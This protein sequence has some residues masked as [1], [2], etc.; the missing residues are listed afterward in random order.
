MSDTPRLP[1][2]WRTPLAALALLL[3]AILGLYAHTASGMVAIWWRS[4]TYAH[5]FVV[6]VIS[7]W[8]IW[9]MRFDLAPLQPR[10][11]P[12]AWLLL[13]GAAGL[14]LAGDLVAVNAATQLALV[15]LLV[16][17]VPAV[18]GWRLAWAMAFPLGFLFFA[19]PIGDFMLPQLMEWTAS[20]TI[21]ALRLSGVPVYREGLQFIIPS[22]SWS[23]VEACSGIRY[24][25][26]SVTVGCLFAYLSYKSL[27]KR[28]IFVG[29]AILV[30]LVANWLRAYMIVMLGHL[31]GNEL[32]TGVDH[33]IYGWLFFG[34]VILAMLFVGAR[35]A[36]APEPSTAPL[37][38]G[39]TVL[40]NQRKLSPGIAALAALLI[41]ASPHLLERLLA[42]GSN[43]SPVVLS[44]PAANAPWQTAAQPPSNW[45]PAFQFPAATSHTGYVGPQGQAVG[46]HLTYYR[47]QNYERK[48]VSSE[49]LFVASKGDG[50][51][52][53]S[54][55]SAETRLADQPLTVSAAT[56]RQQ[57]GGLVAN[58][59]RLQA[60]RFYWVNG[61]FT[62]SD[63]QAK[64]Q[65][66]LSRLT[67]QGDDGAIVAIYAP[68]DASLSEAEARS[69]ANQT[70][71]DFLRVHGT[72]LEE[73]LKR[74][75][76]VP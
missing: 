39:R 30:P 43:S 27:T 49:N 11:S 47:A 26:A 62:A 57:A 9:R 13:L 71:T 48:L 61:R 15:M 5:G 32:A 10:P 42:L 60:W 38:Q 28:V 75:R 37:A 33:L 55:G 18:L 44:V 53:V 76:L 24:M 29:V 34:L 68:L 31:S 51:A 20:F 63:V 59:L 17:T 19:V 74:T 67:G 69:A 4:D 36:D 73:A 7:L 12:L 52:Q 66:A 54:E 58:G 50:W 3:L 35:W 16:L 70:L 64:L 45:T 40:A 22:G 8:L 46:V 56:L 41:V 65:G 14:W 2:H 1:A 6:P 21:L 23:V 72:S 25:I